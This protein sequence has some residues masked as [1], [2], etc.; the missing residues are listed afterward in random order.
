MSTIASKLF[1][2]LQVGAISLKHRVVMAPLTRYRSSSE[3]VHGGVPVEY[4]KQ[5]F[6]EL[7]YLS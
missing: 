6:E 3:H 2:P 4:Y 5:R 1:Q 7:R